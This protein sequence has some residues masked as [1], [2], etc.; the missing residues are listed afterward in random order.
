M[1]RALALLGTALLLGC[2]HDRHEPAETAVASPTAS[3]YTC[4]MH[5]QVV[6]RTPGT[7]PIC[8]MDLVLRTQG[9]A[10]ATSGP[11]AADRATVQLSPEQ[12][13]YLGVQ[14]AAA[15]RRLFARELRTVGTVVADETRVSHVHTKLTGYVEHL[16]ALFVGQTVRKGQPLLSI[17]SPGLLATQEEFLRA[18]AAAERFA[19]STLP[20]VRR[21]GAELLEAARRRLELLDVPASF[22]ADLERDG[23]PIRT[24][25]LPAPASGVIIMKQV[26]DGQQI[27]PGLDLLTIADLSKV[28]VEAALHENDVPVVRLGQQAAV[29]SPYDASLDL[30]GRVVFIDPQVALDT[31]TLRVRSHFA[32]PGLRLKPGMFVDVTLEIDPHQALVIPEGALIETG[33]RQLVYVEQAPGRFE[34][35]E[36]RGGRREGGDVEIVTGLTDGERVATNATF[37]L[38]AESR[39]QATIR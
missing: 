2:G 21:G 19:N 18:R 22:I 16:H 5:P 29:R 36:V 26:F 7:C 30:R 3:L 11:P 23:R 27:E 9:A 34:P 12:S 6:S 28:W 39:I 15:V 35:R 32:N 4:P 20:E 8:H 38:D 1:K 31:R 25:T 13:Q 14:T 37:M 10:T 33:T 24:L 17:Y